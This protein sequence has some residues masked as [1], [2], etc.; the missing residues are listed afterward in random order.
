MA[1]SITVTSLVGKSGVQ[2]NALVWTTTF[3][4]CSG[5]TGLPYLG[6]AV[7]QL[8][9]SQTNNVGSASY[10]GESAAGIFVHSNLGTN[11]T[12]Y[13]WARAVDASGQTSAY[14]PAGGGVQV[15]T[16]NEVPPANSVG[17]TQI[18]DGA[19]VAG[20]IAANAVTATTIAA[21]AVTANAIAANSITSTMIA[22][23]AVTANAIAANAVT[24]GKIAANAITATE[25]AADSITTAKIQAGAVN[26]TSIAVNGVNIQNIV[27]GAATAVAYANGSNV[28][29]PMSY[30][31]TGNIL[32]SGGQD[33]VLASTNFTSVTSVVSVDIQCTY[34]YRGAVDS[35]ALNT[36]F[37]NFVVRINGG[38]AVAYSIRPIWEWSGAYYYFNQSGTFYRSVTLSVPTSNVSYQLVL[39]LPSTHQYDSLLYI[40]ST[41]PVEFYDTFIRVFERRR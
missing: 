14:Y 15:V 8:Y 1:T 6:L 12:W 33:I 23:N 2:Q 28:T 7:V 3:P 27:D 20:K 21:N 17:S 13:Y 36:F 39:N 37:H 29:N 19:V 31:E 30:S 41:Y 10:V 34:R 18:I 9:A 5:P 40:P 26:A 24:A 25:I 38:N 11:A 32:Y 16:K 22:A 4:E 35:G